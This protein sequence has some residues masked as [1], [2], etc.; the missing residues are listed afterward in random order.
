MNHFK[1]QLKAPKLLSALRKSTY[2]S[3]M[4]FEETVH[5]MDLVCTGSAITYLYLIVYVPP[6][7]DYIEKYRVVLSRLFS[8]IKANNLHVMILL[9]E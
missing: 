8:S 3:I 2:T 6:D 7:R 9:M 1:V 5:L 4:D